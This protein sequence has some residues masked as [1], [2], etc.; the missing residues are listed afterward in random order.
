MPDYRRGWRRMLVDMEI[1]GWDERFLSD[2]DPVR[3]ADLY[4]RAG[5]DSVM[6]ACKT[7]GG[8]CLWPTRVGELH[9]ALRGRD[10]VADTVAALD[11]RGLA[12][13]A[14]Y[15]VIY[16]NWAFENHHDWRIE[17]TSGRRPED[18][19]GDRHGWCC[20]NSPGY[21]GYVA[22]Q[23]ADLYG[24]YEVGCAFCDMTFWPHVCGCRHCRDRYRV[25]AGAG[26]PDA[27]D[28]TSPEWCAFAAARESWL[29]EFTALVSDAIRAARPGIAVYHNFATA[30]GHWTRG[31]PFAA[32]E[33]SDFLGGDMYGD[34]VEQLV[35]TKLMN[36]LSRS[37]P[38]E[39]MTFATTGTDE[40]VRLK[41]SERMR[42]HVLAARA[43]SAAMMFIDAIDPAGT[44][45]PG[46]YDRV[47]E[48]FESSIALEPHL[49]GDPVEDVAIYFSSESRVDFAENGSS[50]SD[51]EA[52][53]A[54]HPHLEALRGA[55]RIMARAHISFGVITRRQLD[56]LHR[57]PVIVLPNVLRM[58]AEEAGTLREYVRRGGRIYA[59]RYT[60]LV[61]TRGV[62]HEDFMLADVFGVHLEREERCR[63]VYAK[64]AADRTAV[65]TAPQHYVSANP[66]AGSLAGGLLRLRSDP[67]AEVLATLTLPYAHPE[68]G[69]VFDHRW[70]SIHSSPP[71]EDSGTPVL[72]EHSY[73]DGRAVYSAF[74]LEREEADVNHR[75]FAEL[76][77]SLLGDDWSW[78]CDTAPH[79]WAS[80][81]S[82]PDVPA[83]RIALL[84]AP[85]AIVAGATLR[86][87]PPAGTRFETLRDLSSGE[88]PAFATAFDG[89]LEC[90]LESLPELTMLRATYAEVG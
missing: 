8:L 58:D 23:I 55:S 89:T 42:A 76:V 81:F 79:V 5:V 10:V 75:V 69:T 80:A 88:R 25:E 62:P 84:N 74:D 78:Q 31:V 38:V 1:P 39:Y 7:L 19:E 43:E 61:E 65:A 11:E 83:I 26:L 48:A 50:L 72:V 52:R 4:A 36:G 18:D 45:N 73:G 27:I 33:H 13:C 29:T 34:A 41:S 70:S 32:A 14:Y 90:R 24:R 60:S 35:V 68:L 53:W 71:W 54:G 21:R 63:I 67:A 49:G 2:Y 57:Y 22:E 44:A 56:V 30:P 37:R 51:Y 15:S 12:A 40:H 17:P 87:R 82:E 85:P 86:L 77:R 59:S 47:R 28:W 3:M 6:F 66:A 9:P 46:H 64:P 16:D 20:P